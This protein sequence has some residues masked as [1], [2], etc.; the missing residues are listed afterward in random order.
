MQIFEKFPSEKELLN[1]V[2]GKEKGLGYVYGVECGKYVKIG[3]TFNPK[4]R[5]PM[6]QKYAEKYG[7]SASKVALS[8][9]HVNYKE[10]EIAIHCNFSDF[11][12][13][14]TELF[15]IS[16]YDFTSFL[17]ST[18]IS[19][20]KKYAFPEYD[21]NKCKLENIGAR[22]RFYRKKNML[23]QEKL[24]H[25]MEVSC[26]TINNWEKGRTEPNLSTCVRIAALFGVKLEELLEV[27][28]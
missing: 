13:N 26:A 22:I 20:I 12:K 8:N 10:N 5:I 15:E 14:G 4:A 6:I 25:I 9:L 24:S 28:K 3:S 11:R 7:L 17:N 2:N 23:S 19:F 18:K 16:F 27:S 1:F 21:E